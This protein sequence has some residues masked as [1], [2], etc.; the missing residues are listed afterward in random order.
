MK[1]NKCN[2]KKVFIHELGHFI[3]HLILYENIG[4]Y[5]PVK[6]E[7][8][9]DN[10]RKCYFGKHIHKNKNSFNGL[11]FYINESR[12]QEFP[13]ILNTL[14][15][16]IFQAIYINNKVE[17][18]LCRECIDGSNDNSQVNKVYLDYQNYHKKEKSE[19]I[20]SM[21]LDKV[22]ELN[23]GELLLKLDEDFLLSTKDPD[24][25]YFEY[26]SE[27]LISNPIIVEI[28]FRLS[29]LFMRAYNDLKR[30]K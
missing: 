20:I 10:E 25:S 4:E 11:P 8:I 21:H 15:G 6:I 26:S 19:E 3:S 23:L 22:L 27:Y 30:L 7:I 1:K 12:I 16:C 2:F 17:L 9:W 18:Q 24:S 14:Y 28:K 29:S 5:D 13:I